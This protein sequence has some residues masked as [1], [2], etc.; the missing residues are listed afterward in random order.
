MWAI[1]IITD[2]TDIADIAIWMTYTVGLSEFYLQNFAS[3]Y[4]F[5]VPNYGQ[6]RFCILLAISWPSL[7]GTQFL[8][9]YEGHFQ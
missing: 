4:L 3:Q 5:S 9:L 6:K 2:I 1:S 8:P 7:I